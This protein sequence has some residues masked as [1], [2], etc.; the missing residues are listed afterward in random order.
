MPTGVKPAL[1]LNSSSPRIT[2]SLEMEFRE[3]KLS[4][5]LVSHRRWWGRVGS[6]SYPLTKAEFSAASMCFKPHKTS[7]YDTPN[8]LSVSNEHFINI[9]CCGQSKGSYGEINGVFS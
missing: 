5:W 8:K 6:E 3:V 7:R 4:T 2:E 9:R 1:K